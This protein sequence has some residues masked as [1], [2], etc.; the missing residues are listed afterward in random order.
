MTP[1]SQ[2]HVAGAG[3]GAAAPADDVAGG[4]GS[5]AP[6]WGLFMAVPGSPALLPAVVP[7]PWAAEA[8]EL[9]VGRRRAQRSAPGRAC[10]ARRPGAERS[11]RAGDKGPG[12]GSFVA[13]PRR[14]RLGDGRGRQ[15]GDGPEA[16]PPPEPG[17]LAGAGAGAFL[18][19]R[20]RAGPTHCWKR[21]G[22]GERGDS[23]PESAAPAALPV[24]LQS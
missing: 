14:E 19:L 24:R 11:V 13:V 10:G 6:W 23:H 12:R 18:G 21:R 1:G 17:R 3:P 7:S 22:W 20:L 8:P 5:A 9:E 4:A 2:A 16:P 15:K